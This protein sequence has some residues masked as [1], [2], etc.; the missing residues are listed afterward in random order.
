MVI[1]FHIDFISNYVY[2]Y[3]SEDGSAVESAGQKRLGDLVW[4]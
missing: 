2:V 3:G 4:R 1:S